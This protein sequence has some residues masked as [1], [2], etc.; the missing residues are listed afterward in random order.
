[1]Q[2]RSEALDQLATLKHTISHQESISSMVVDHF[3][4]KL[5]EL[6]SEARENSIQFFKHVRGLEINFYQAFLEG[7]SFKAPYQDYKKK[8]K[9]RYY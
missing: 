9:S 8:E 6:S 1:M 4:V 7:V 3:T 2:Q 5:E